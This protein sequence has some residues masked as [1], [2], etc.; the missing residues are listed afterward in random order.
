MV[1]AYSLFYM[2]E[3]SG[4]YEFFLPFLLV[5]V[6]VFAILE[7]TY[8]F[9]K[10]ENNGPKTNIN[11]VVAVLISL[12]MV[13]QTDLVLFM[14]SYLS[15]MALF[16]V[17]GIMFMLVVAMFAGARGNT[18]F[19]GFGLTAG[20]IIAIVA[21]LWSLSSGMYGS[22]FPYWFYISE[23]VISVLL[24][25]GVLVLVIALVAKGGNSSS[26]KKKKK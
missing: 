9:G 3:S 11:M 2:L 17:I 19:E 6:I 24:M 5:F 15:R 10:N 14:E 1:D 4:M 22:A 23:S 7:K 12:L 25:L 21:L 16:M 13:V 20:V 8:I 18:E 26:G